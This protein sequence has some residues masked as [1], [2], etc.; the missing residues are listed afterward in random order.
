M[1]KLPF[2]KNCVLLAPMAGMTDSGFR[3]VCREY[4]ADGTVSEMVSSRG[5]FYGDEKSR[6][7]MKRTEGEEPFAIQL[8]GNDPEFMKR[9]AEY[10]RENFS[11]VMIDINMGCPAPKIFKNGDGCALMRDP[12]LAE[13]LVAAVKSE[14]GSPV[15][16]KFRSGV[17]AE[18][19]NAVEFAAACESGGADMLTVHGRTRDQFYS[20]SSDPEIIKRVVESVSVPVIANGDVTDGESAVKLLDF[21]G[22]YGVMVGRAALGDPLVFGRIKQALVPEYEPKRARLTDVAMEQLGYAV[23]DK[24]EFVAVREFRGHMLHYLKGVRNAAELKRQSSRAI[25]VDDCRRIFEA[26]EE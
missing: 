21:T 19:I 11:P 25:T 15:S 17:D 26:V 3:R 5:L 10:V 6:A 13:K 9:A 18:H 20:G 16:V 4:G 14:S 24:G 23:K 2:K 1:K 22:A 8:F 12:A 7:L